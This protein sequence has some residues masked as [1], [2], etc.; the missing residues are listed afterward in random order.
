MSK[1]TTLVFISVVLPFVY[2]ETGLDPVLLPR[3]IFTGCFLLV[4]FSLFLIKKENSYFN[5][6]SII[7]IL[8]FLGFIVFTLLSTLHSQRLPIGLP[9]WIRSVFLIALAWAVLFQLKGDLEIDEIF[10]KALALSALSI[11]IIADIQ[12]VKYGIS[13]PMKITSTLANKNLLSSALFILAP[14]LIYNILYMKRVWRIIIITAFFNLIFLLGVLMSRAIWFG[15]ITVVFMG[16][17]LILVLLIRKKIQI[18]WSKKQTIYLVIGVFLVGG[19]TF[20]IL[21]NEDTRRN[22]EKKYNQLTSLELAHTFSD[23][24]SKV[25]NPGSLETRLRLWKSTLKMANNS[26]FLGVGL[27]SWKIEFPRQGLSDFDYDVRQG[28]KHFQRPHN[29]FLWVLAETGYPGLTFYV[30]LF[31]VVLFAGIR[32]VLNQR[33]KVR[34]VCFLF[35]I[36]L[37]GYLTISFFDFPAERMYHGIVIMILTAFLLKYSDSKPVW[38]TNKVRYLI[39]PILLL[40]IICIYSLVQNFKGEIQSNR[41]ITAQ[42]HGKWDDL[43]RESKKVNRNYY[44]IDHFA[45]PVDWYEGIAWFTKGDYQRALVHFKEAQKTA[46]NHLQVLNNLAS[47]YEVLGLHT[48]SIATYKEALSVSPSFEE[49]IVN[50]AIVYYNQNEKEKAY[51]TLRNCS[52]SSSQQ[53]YN[54]ILTTILREKYQNVFYRLSEKEVLDY[55]KQNIS[56]NDLKRLFSHSIEKNIDIESLFITYLSDN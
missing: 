15:S 21:K 48:E 31:G 28:R 50:L 26:P 17:L 6:I 51:E 43:I 3:M 11:I 34:A 41:I 47:C 19:L 16:I 9:E 18:N 30:L 35:T 42:L 45:T 46:P 39:P 12:I 55:Q 7:W 53:N 29:D 25:K 14:A 54:L 5:S 37:S 2:T 23:D 24:N 32:G 44:S 56:N 52:R 22:L 40:L 20:F 38:Q 27:G 8:V 1:S 10:I 4:V 36:F 13:D 33:G 49:A